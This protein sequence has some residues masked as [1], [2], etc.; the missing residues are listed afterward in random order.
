MTEPYP[1]FPLEVS[2]KFVYPFKIN[3]IPRFSMSDNYVGLVLVTYNDDDNLLKCTDSLDKTLD[4]PTDIIAIDLG[5]TDDTLE[6][7][8]Y[9]TGNPGRINSNI[10]SFELIRK[11]KLE[12][13]TRTLNYGFQYLM[14][15]QECEYIGWVHPDM[16]FED[17]WLTQL[18]ATLMN[19]PEVGKINSFNTRNGEPSIEEV[20]EGHEQCYLIP[21]GVLLKIGLFDEQFLG[22]GGYEDWDLNSRIRQEGYKVAIQP[23]SRVYHQGMGTRSKS[24]NSF[25]EQYNLKQYEKKWGTDKESK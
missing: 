22:C 17:C 15:R 1:I 23:K 4:Y 10:K 19:H 5:S 24:D 2:S 16:V 18:V 20:Y 12:A 11:P 8:E 6:I 21:R 14:R 7:L 3:S 9:Y 13:L 25:F